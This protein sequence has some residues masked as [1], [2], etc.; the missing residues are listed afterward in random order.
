MDNM[1]IETGIVG[2][3]PELIFNL[4]DMT[5]AQHCALSEATIGVLTMA[6]T[7]VAGI[8]T[9][10]DLRQRIAENVHWNTLCRAPVTTAYLNRI[11][12]RVANKLDDSVGNVVEIF[13]RS[14][15]FTAFVEGPKTA[16]VSTPVWTAVNEQWEGLDAVTLA[17]FKGNWA[18]NTK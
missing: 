9:P 10:K 16:V 17:L 11:F 5:F 13:L 15:R 3:P 18:A 7:R 6:Q 12:G 2:I 8:N 4:L 1:D 14:K